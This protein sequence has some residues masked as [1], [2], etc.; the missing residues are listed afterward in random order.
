MMDM[1]ENSLDVVMVYFVLNG[2]RQL[3]ISLDVYKHLNTD[4]LF[5]KLIA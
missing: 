1:L 3:S 5:P 4:T 2:I